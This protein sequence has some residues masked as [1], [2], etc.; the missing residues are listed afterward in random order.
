MMTIAVTVDSDKDHSLDLASAP[1]FER[2]LKECIT[3]LY[4]ILSHTFQRYEL[5]PSVLNLHTAC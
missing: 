2:G 1:G 4:Q 5:Y 3:W